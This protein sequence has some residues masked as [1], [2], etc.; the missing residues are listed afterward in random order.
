MFHVTIATA[1]ILTAVLATDRDLFTLKT[2]THIC[3]LTIKN[4]SGVFMKKILLLI[5]AFAG[6]LSCA[7][8]SDSDDS[9]GDDSY[10][11]GG[12]QLLRA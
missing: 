9:G 6:I 3:C 2:D 4:N 5:M 7:G 1:D 10:N 8:C 11:G 12:F